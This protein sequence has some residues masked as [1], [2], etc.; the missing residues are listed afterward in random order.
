VRAQDIFHHVLDQLL[1]GTNNALE[2][3]PDMQ[4]YFNSIDIYWAL[5][6]KKANIHS[7]GCKRKSE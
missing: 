1:S 2:N 3:C 4:T 5:P 7:N 6:M